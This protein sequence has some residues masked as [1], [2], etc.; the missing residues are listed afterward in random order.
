M[1]HL[2][3]FLLLCFLNWECS[4]TEIP[5]VTNDRNQMT[6]TSEVVI[7]SYVGTGV[8]WGGYDLLEEWTG[9]P[10]LTTSDWDKLFQRVRFMRP[11]IVRIMVSEGWNYMEDNQ[12]APEKSAPVLFKILDFCQAESIEVVFGEWG[13]QGGVGIDTV[14]L[15]N[16]AKFLEYVVLTKGYSCITT[17]NMVNEPNGDWSSINGNYALWIMLIEQFHKKL[18]EKGLDQRIK[19][20]GPDIAVW[21]AGLTSWIRNTNADLGTKIDVYDIHTYPKESEVRDGSYLEMIKAY[22]EVAPTSKDMI[23]GELGFK[24]SVLSELGIQNALRISADEYS[25]DDSNMFVYDSFYGIDMADAVMQNMLA[26]FAGVILWDLD[27]AMYNKGYAAATKLK[28]WGFWNILGSEKF[29]KSSDENIRPWFYTMSLMSR[30]FPAGTT[31]YRMTLPEKYGLRAVAGCKNG[32]WTIAV[33]NSNTVSYSLKLKMQEGLKLS[34][35]RK[36][37]FLSGEKSAFTGSVDENGFALPAVTD[38]SIDFSGD[39]AYLLSMPAQSFCL[40]TNMQLP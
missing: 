36:Y 8:Q 27:D 11:P 14:W 30:F 24:Y 26:G 38:M 13:H 19:L 7:A 10:T 39:A 3:L 34:G 18:T 6:I 21:T 15:E 28:R 2:P 22:R 40:Y 1:L 17:Y 31:I 23:M 4:N 29:D 16:A 9:S 32:T 35:I 37:S 5:P 25:S 12:F 33:V 20:V